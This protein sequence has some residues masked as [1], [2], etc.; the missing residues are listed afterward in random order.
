MACLSSARQ[1]GKRQIVARPTHDEALAS[2]FVIVRLR[3]S[4][5][6]V[7]RIALGKLK[8]NKWNSLFGIFLC[9]CYVL[10]CTSNTY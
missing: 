6:E 2:V 9:N 1:R 8:K 3:S 5:A 4:E 10:L 7:F